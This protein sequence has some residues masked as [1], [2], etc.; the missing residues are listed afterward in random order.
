MNQ[1][2]VSTTGSSVA[3]FFV[4]GWIPGAEE[5]TELPLTLPNNSTPA[6]VEEAFTH[7]MHHVLHQFNEKDLAELKEKHGRAIIVESILRSDSPVVPFDNLPDLTKA[8]P[9]IV[10]FDD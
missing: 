4:R 10:K 6:Q 7:E 8:K 2:Q 9:V 5:A 1:Q 3:Y